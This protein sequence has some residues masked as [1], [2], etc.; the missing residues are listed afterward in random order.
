MD[1]GDCAGASRRHPGAPRGQA[2]RRKKLIALL[3]ATSGIQ[4]EGEKPPD[5]DPSH[6]T[7]LR[8]WRMLANGMGGIDWAGLPIVADMLGITDPQAL[9]EHLTLIKAYKPKETN[10]TGNP[11]D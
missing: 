2:G 10:G 7:A 9:I 8:A 4:Y 3:D 11:L 5:P 6:L 1:A